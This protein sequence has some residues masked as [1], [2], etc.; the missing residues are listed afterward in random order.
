[1][2]GFGAGGM[3]DGNGLS[4]GTAIAVPV[5]VVSMCRTTLTIDIIIHGSAADGVGADHQGSVVH[6]VSADRQVSGAALAFAEDH[7]SELALVS[8]DLEFAA[9]GSG[10][11]AKTM[12]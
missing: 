9:V 1:M 4:A 7:A 8:V 12:T 11:D 6:R 5:A 10:A 3:A 2:A